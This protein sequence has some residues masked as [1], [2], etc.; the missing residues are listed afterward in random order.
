[1][2][3]KRKYRVESKPV[4]YHIG[5]N[6]YK[7]YKL[8]IN[9]LSKQR[10]LKNKT[11]Y[12]QKRIKELLALSK[13]R[14]KIGKAEFEKKIKRFL[15]IRK[16]NTLNLN[17]STKYGI[18]MGVD[19]LVFRTIKR[20]RV[21][22]PID[23]TITEWNKRYVEDNWEDIASILNEYNVLAYFQN[24]MDPEYSDWFERVTAALGLIGIGY[25]NFLYP[26]MEVLKKRS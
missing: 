25:S 19:G 12:Q 3:K 7:D 20:K 16:N 8:V 11:K 6:N 13:N 21:Y 26:I 10:S 18:K 1:M 14:S 9:A 23:H 24:F 17:K 2:N 22:G 4:G 5:F 15:G